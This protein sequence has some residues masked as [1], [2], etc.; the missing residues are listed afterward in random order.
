M[1]VCP[2]TGECLHLIS[3]GTETTGTRESE[4]QGRLYTPTHSPEKAYHKKEWVEAVNKM[5]PPGRGNPPTKETPTDKKR[6]R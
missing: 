5:I 1:G 6:R 4:N 3:E 2:A